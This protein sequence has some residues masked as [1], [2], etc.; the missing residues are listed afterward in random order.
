MKIL[1]YKTNIINDDLYW[2]NIG[3]NKFQISECISNEST[4]DKIII[5]IDNKKF[6]LLMKKSNK[7]RKMEE[8]VV[9]KNERNKQKENQSFMSSGSNQKQQPI[10]ENPV[11]SPWYNP[12]SIIQKQVSY[13]KEYVKRMEY[14]TSQCLQHMKDIIHLILKGLDNAVIDDDILLILLD[15]IKKKFVNDEMYTIDSLEIQEKLKEYLFNQVISIIEKQIENKENIIMGYPALKRFDLSNRLI[16]NTEYKI[17][18]NELYL[19]EEDQSCLSKDQDTSQL[20]TKNEVT[21][22]SEELSQILLTMDDLKSMEVRNNERVKFTNDLFKFMVLQGMP[23]YDL[24][25]IN[26]VIVDIFLLYKL[27]TAHGGFV[28]VTKLKLWP[29]IYNKIFRRNYRI[30]YH[31]NGYSPKIGS[32]FLWF[33]YK[34]YLHSYERLKEMFPTSSWLLSASNVYYSNIEKR[35]FLKRKDQLHNEGSNLSNEAIKNLV[36]YLRY[37][38]YPN[39]DLFPKSITYI[40][41]ANYNTDKNVATISSTNK[42]SETSMSHGKLPSFSIFRKY[43]PNIQ[44][45]MEMEMKKDSSSKTIFQTDN[46]KRKISCLANKS[47]ISSSSTNQIKEEPQVKITHLSCVPETTLL[48]ETISRKEPEF[49]EETEFVID[50]FTENYLLETIGGGIPERELQLNFEMDIRTEVSSNDSNED[51]Y[52]TSNSTPDEDYFTPNSTLDEDYFTPNSTLDEDYLS[53]INSW[54][55]EQKI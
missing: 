20:K 8:P 48:T 40:L 15:K 43:P 2:I 35:T 17:I 31:I 46:R 25:D 44:M 4:N 51:V 50:E 53:L 41:E 1:E 23:I 3:G 22:S 30:N 45:K 49:N 36:Q 32:S 24:P 19:P 14:D 47:E 28:E 10:V 29:E 37:N 54:I 18:G 42:I 55:E 13:D 21:L 7:I 33:Y 9:R 12:E 16:N 26:D 39:P 5:T 11:F 27:V 34:Q 38:R 52:F 6:K